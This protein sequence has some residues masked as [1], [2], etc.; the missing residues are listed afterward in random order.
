V[1]SQQKKTVLLAGL[2]QLG[3]PLTGFLGGLEADQRDLGG[4]IRKAHNVDL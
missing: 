3:E 4:G 1:V 2:V